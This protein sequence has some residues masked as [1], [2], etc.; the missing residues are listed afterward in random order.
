[1]TKS[2]T[3]EASPTLVEA[4]PTLLCRA[5]AIV[6]QRSVQF[7]ALLLLCSSYLQ[8]GIDKLLDFAG[9][10]TEVRLLGLAPA[11]FFAVATIVTELCGSALV[12]SGVF[13]WL[14]AFWLAAFTL[15]AIFW[16]IDFGTFPC[17]TASWWKMHFSSTSASSEGSSWSLGTIL[18]EANRRER[19]PESAAKATSVRDRTVMNRPGAAALLSAYLPVLVICDAPHGE[20]AQQS[21]RHH[22][23]S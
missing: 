19:G 6:T 22:G 11:A 14:G 21:F 18:G 10:V 16:Q 2:D 15:V 9:A 13:R 7:V 17:P 8:G 3:V 1:V 5:R 12:L 20:R 4:N 23:L